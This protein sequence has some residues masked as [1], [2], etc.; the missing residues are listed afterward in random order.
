LAGDLLQQIVGNAANAEAVGEQRA[1][2]RNR[3]QQRAAACQR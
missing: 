1:V 3:N 2:I